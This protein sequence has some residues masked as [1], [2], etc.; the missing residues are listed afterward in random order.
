MV[1]SSLS[2]TKGDVMNKCKQGKDGTVHHVSGT[3]CKG[4]IVVDGFGKA[5]IPQ[6]FGFKDG[7]FIVDVLRLKVYQGVCMECGRNGEFAD[8]NSIKAST[9]PAD[10]INKK[11]L[12]KLI[13][14]QVCPN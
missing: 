1:I 8:V 10:N 11:I 12:Q 6:S 13:S 5:K 7:L 2:Q 3:G 4:K 14:M 9:E